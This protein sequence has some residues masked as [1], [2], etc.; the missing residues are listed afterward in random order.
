MR[1]FRSLGRSC[2]AAAGAAILAL[3]VGAC[4]GGATSPT[5]ASSSAGSAPPSSA[6]V[7]PSSSEGGSGGLVSLPAPE[8]TS[9]K[10][11]TSALEANT[12]VARY[13]QEKGLYKKYG[14]DADVQ[15]FEGS[16]AEQ[17]LLAGQVEA[18]RGSLETS[19]FSQLTD[20]PVI[21]VGAYYNH[22]LDDFVGGTDIKTADDLKGKRVGTSSFGGLSHRE[23]LVALQS[24]GLTEKD[25][26]LVEIG[27][28]SE[29]I[30]AL[31]AGSVSAVPLDAALRSDME[32]AGFNVLVKLAE[33]PEEV[34]NGALMVTKK[35]AVANPN[36]TLAIVA[37]N[38]DAMQLLFSDTDDAVKA[39]AA[40]AQLDQADAD[41][42]MRQFLTVAQRDLHWT[43]EST[44]QF[45]TFLQ[46]QDPTIADVDPASTY[47]FEFLDR[48]EDLGLFK[49]LGV[50]GY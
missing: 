7:S 39:L 37:A 5:P 23:A 4:S 30:A 46:L 48:L 10:I 50:P 29:R 9:I 31:K 45:K 17:A 26:S 36:T 20:E 47:S 22:F 35:F 2:R 21:V 12:F 13:A 8:K 3:I 24:L 44:A 14:V 18:I 11:A 27:G 6:P 28:Q 49:Q 41:R 42:T 19:F 43:P 15:F 38:L 40:W 16:Q 25:V 34:T 1:E 33:T 32:S